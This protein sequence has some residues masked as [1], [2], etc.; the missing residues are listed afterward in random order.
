MPLRNGQEIR[1][2]AARHSSLVQYQNRAR[3]LAGVAGQAA[4]ILHIADRDH[5]RVKHDHALL[6]IEQQLPGQGGEP[7]P[8]R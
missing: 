7:L 5:R 4:R 3:I 6:G 2:Q 1:R 8:S